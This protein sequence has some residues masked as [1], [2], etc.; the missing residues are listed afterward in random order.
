LRRLNP[1]YKCQHN[2]SPDRP[3]PFDKKQNNRT[4]ETDEPQYGSGEMLHRLTFGELL[5][6]PLVPGVFSGLAWGQELL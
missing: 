5:G 3:E 6:E 4:L 2:R 1:A